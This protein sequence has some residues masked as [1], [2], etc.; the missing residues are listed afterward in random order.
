MDTASAAYIPL[1]ERFNFRMIGFGLVV[2]LLLGYPMYVYVDSAVS[3][4]I[5]ETGEGYKAV[6]L[7]AMSS[8][9]FDQNNGTIDDVPAKWRALDGQKVILE[10]EM[11]QPMSA[12]DRLG[13]FE[14]VYSI[15]KCCT[16]GPPQIQHFVHSKVVN[17]KNVDYYSGLVRVRGTLHVDVKRAEGKVVSV[18]ELDVEDVESM[19]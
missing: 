17:G 7:Q 14:L 4:G 12:G 15:S 10:G 16:T 8:F 9:L 5:K 6:E 18:Y 2:L 1:S 11:W 13:S 19:G 3:G